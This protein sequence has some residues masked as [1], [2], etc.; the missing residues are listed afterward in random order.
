MTDQ[1]SKPVALY[2]ILALIL[3]QGLSGIIGGIG[4]ILDPS[5]KSL[6]IPLEWLENSP[7][8]NY[9]IPGLI[10]F[11]VLGIFP[12]FVFRGLLKKWKNIWLGALSIAIML[13][14]WIL[15]EILIISYQAEPPLQLIYGSV[16]ILL[17][18]FTLLPSVKKYYTE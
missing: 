12:L 6:Q 2:I 17:L 14:I 7:F 18:I 8:S 1:G 11:F 5:G 16:G 3:F 10:L 13:I 4:L 15:V 9:L